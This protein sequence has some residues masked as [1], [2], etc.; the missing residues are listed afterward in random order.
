MVKS[1][2]PPI[3]KLRPELLEKSDAELDR[4]IAELQMAKDAKAVKAEAERRERLTGEAIAHMDQ[5]VE[6]LKWLEANGFMSEKVRASYTTAG[7]V[8]APH[9]SFKRPR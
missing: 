5:V 8:F 4:L 3:E 9:L 1:V 2:T 6:S 7:G